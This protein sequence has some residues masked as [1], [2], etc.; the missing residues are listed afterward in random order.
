[1]S[2]SMNK[3]LQQQLG[4]TTCQPSCSTEHEGVARTEQLLSIWDGTDTG[5]RVLHSTLQQQSWPLALAPMGLRYLSLWKQWQGFLYWTLCIGVQAEGCC[6][7]IFMQT[8]PQDTSSGEDAEYS[9]QQWA[10]LWVYCS[11]TANCGF[12]PLWWPPTTGPGIGEGADFNPKLPSPHPGE[13]GAVKHAHSPA[14][15]KPMAC[16]VWLAWAAGHL[17]LSDR[18]KFQ[19]SRCRPGL[20]LQQCVLHSGCPLKHWY[21]SAAPLAGLDTSEVS[22]AQSCLQWMWGRCTVLKMCREVLHQGHTCCL[23]CSVYHRTWLA[24]PR[25]SEL[26]SSDRGRV[27][28]QEIPG[29]NKKDTRP[30]CLVTSLLPVDRHQASKR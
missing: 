19:A 24:L 6:S 12:T 13:T 26:I 29:H 14:H 16:T 21:S 3:I 28:T 22:L 2:Q 25:T 23:S 11:C 30:C 1:M 20:S 4:A 10:L 8:W 15:C 7:C 18:K 9:C 5:T 17:P 27:K